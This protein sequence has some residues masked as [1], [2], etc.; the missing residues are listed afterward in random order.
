MRSSFL[1]YG[2]SLALAC[3]AAATPLFAQVNS[4]AGGPGVDPNWT[5]ACSFTIAAGGC[6]SGSAYVVAG[7]PGVWPNLPSAAWI[8]T[9]TSASVS[10]A[11]TSN[12]ADNYNYVFS[13]TFAATTSP[14]TMSVWTDNF[15]TAF[16]T[17]G[18]SSTPVTLASSPGDFGAGAPR[19]FLLPTGTTSVQLSTYGDGTTDGVDVAFS[20]VP[21]PSS[22]ALL[23]TGLIGLVPMIRRKRKV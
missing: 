11:K 16:A 14:L 22:I 7:Q 17:N 18:G 19:S 5:V 2:A 1:K 12:N 13:Q 4:G 9:S 20:S 21:E 3:A 23:G 10:G 15:F 8:S 6:H